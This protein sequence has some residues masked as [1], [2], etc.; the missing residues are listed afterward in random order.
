MGFFNLRAPLGLQSLASWGAAPLQL[1]PAA[2][3]RFMVCERCPF[4]VGRAGSKLTEISLALLA[5]QFP[6]ASR[7]ILQGSTNTSAAFWLK[8][9]LWDLNFFTEL[10]SPKRVW[11]LSST[12]LPS[13]TWI[14][15]IACIW[16]KRFPLRPS[17]MV[18]NFGTI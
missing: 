10:S 16:R 14:P 3:L 5:F 11:A 6:P 7:C 2:R 12:R 8:I 15:A 17:L 1:R 9:F 13:R 4:S 18:R